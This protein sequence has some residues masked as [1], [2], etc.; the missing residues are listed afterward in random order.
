M[1]S[2][3]EDSLRDWTILFLTARGV[4]ND[5]A[6]SHTPHPRSTHGWGSLHEWSGEGLQHLLGATKR[7]F[8]T[9]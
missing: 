9:S 1:A 8:P 5:D 3:I 7:A 4:A 2:P 6:H